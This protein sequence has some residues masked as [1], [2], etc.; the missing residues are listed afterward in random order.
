M[1]SVK[2]E[3]N[4]IIERFINPLSVVGES[5]IVQLLDGGKFRLKVTGCK[6]IEKQT[7]LNGYDDEMLNISVDVSDVDFVR[8]CK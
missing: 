3:G 7:L 6:R 1:K 2:F 4:T 8:V 5:I